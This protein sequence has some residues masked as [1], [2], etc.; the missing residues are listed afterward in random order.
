MSVAWTVRVWR[1]ADASGPTLLVL[2][3]LA[4]NADEATGISW[5]SIAYLCTKTRMDERRVQRCLQR[6][7]RDGLVRIESRPGH[8]NRYHLTLRGDGS[9]VRGDNLGGGPSVTPGVAPVSPITV[10]EPSQDK[11]VARRARLPADF[12]L[13]PEREATARRLG[14]RTPPALLEAFRDYWHGTGKPM[15]DWERTF[16]TWARRAHGGPPQLAC[17]CGGRPRAAVEQAREAASAPARA[18]PDVKPTLTPEERRRV[19]QMANTW[20]R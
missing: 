12:G 10:S 9:S 2:L 17:P 1:D 19:A 20:R 6:L 11:A 18:I 15:A 16:A 5:P 3:A 8:S 7:K 4:D 13:T 14:C